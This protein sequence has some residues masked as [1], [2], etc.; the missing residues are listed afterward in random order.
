MTQHGLSVAS[1]VGWILGGVLILL[2]FSLFAGSSRRRTH[3]GGSGHRSRETEDDRSHE[4]IRPDGYIDSFAH[5]IEEAGGPLPPLVLIAL[6]GVIL[7]WLIY[8]I[9]YM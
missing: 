6:P 4:T 3:P 2:I 9:L 7:W 1:Q 8:M 5:D